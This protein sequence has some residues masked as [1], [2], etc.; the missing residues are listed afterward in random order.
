MSSGR[1]EILLLH[2]IDTGAS[3]VGYEI[4]AL[5]L[6]LFVIQQVR[7][8]VDVICSCVDYCLFDPISLIKTHVPENL[9]TY[10]VLMSM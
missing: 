8:G 7:I 4:A 1:N 10:V 9:R 5:L 2:H 3:D 6:L